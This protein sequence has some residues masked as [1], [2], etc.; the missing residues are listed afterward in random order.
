MKIAHVPVI[1]LIAILLILTAC[2]AAASPTI[3]PPAV[4]TIPTRIIT[5][6]FYD[7]ENQQTIL[8]NTFEAS[9]GGQISA[10]TEV[11]SKYEIDN[12]LF[13]SGLKSL[14]ISSNINTTKW[15][16]ISKQLLSDYFEITVSY[17][18]KGKDINIVKG[19]PENCYIGFVITDKN[20]NKKLI[21]K[22][23][24]GTFNWRQDTIGLSIDQIKS[25]R[26]SNST[27][28]LGIFM[29]KSGDLWIDDLKFEFVS[30]PTLAQTT[31]ATSNVAK[32]VII[33]SYNPNP[34][35]IV[36]GHINWE[37]ILTETKGIGV[38]IKSITSQFCSS[39]GSV[40]TPKI[41]TSSNW[42]NNL[43][44][45]YLPPNSKGIIGCGGN[46]NS[47]VSGY[48]IDTITGIDDNGQEI[49][50]TGRVDFSK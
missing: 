3:S 10:S 18:V 2:S 43:P 6:E 5:T 19:R 26:D 4:E 48:Q 25:I 36:V 14:K 24:E 50:I 39:S 21:T 16:F 45:A 7:F 27:L 41:I 12:L 44:G 46:F 33:V 32:A 8:P 31:A 34:V 15:Y 40:G 20:G 42:F 29:T 23:Y 22:D 1:L 47:S 49:I 17:F 30:I 9:V 38:T 13:K 11:P 37:L 35:K 28:C